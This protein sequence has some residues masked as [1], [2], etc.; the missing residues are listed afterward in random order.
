AAA[1]NTHRAAQLARQDYEADPKPENKTY[2]V[3]LYQK[4]ADLY[5]QFIETYPTAEESYEFTYRLGETLF[6][7]EQYLA[8][9]PYY[10]WVRSHRELSENRFEKAAKS[11]VQ[12]YEM[13]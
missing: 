8:S 5:R 12:A 1:E 3:G 7:S 10:E 13:E 6:F 9:I 2:Y 11:I 4:A